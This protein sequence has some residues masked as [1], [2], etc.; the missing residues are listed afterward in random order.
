IAEHKSS[1]KL[2]KSLQISQ[3]LSVILGGIIGFLVSILT[4]NFAFFVII[5]SSSLVISQLLSPY[6][7][8]DKE[9]TQLLEKKRIVLSFYDSFLLFSS[10]TSSFQEGFNQAVSELEISDLKDSLV[11]YQ[12]NSLKGDLPL[13]I[14]NT[15]IEND[16][17]V[18]FLALLHDTEEAS[19]TDIDEF[20]SLL[21]KYQ[22]EDD[23]QPSS[24][25]LNYLPW[26]LIFS[27]LFAVLGFYLTGNV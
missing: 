13:I 11:Q 2:Q 12:E 19:Q 5:L 4:K 16:I 25:L 1:K 27:F 20:N 24:S 14:T 23:T 6:N 22:K 3:L 7:R 10:L 17:S 8:N 15:R 18:S 21:G 26:I 9:L